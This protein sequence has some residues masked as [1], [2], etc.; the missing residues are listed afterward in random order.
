[1]TDRNPSRPEDVPDPQ[2]GEAW[3]VTYKGTHYEALYWYS[4]IYAHWT[5]APN[6]EGLTTIESH[7]ATPMHRLV[8]EVQA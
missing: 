8:P 4:P 5:L 3:L 2:P 7:E 1:M 6:R